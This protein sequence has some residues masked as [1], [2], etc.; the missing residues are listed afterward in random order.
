ME[1]FN[2]IHVFSFGDIQIISK[3]KNGTVK[4][5]DLT[6]LDAFVNHVKTFKPA[7]ITFTDYHTIN[8]FYDNSVRYI[9][10]PDVDKKLKTS[11]SVEFNKI[12]QTILN[13]LVAEVISKI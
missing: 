7:E 12:D 11:F 8:V 9:G 1:T 2:T 13:D 4:A 5:A 6:K 10:K 3:D